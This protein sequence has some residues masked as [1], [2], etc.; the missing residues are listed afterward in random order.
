M[1]RRREHGD[2]WHCQAEPPRERRTLCDQPSQ[3]WPGQAGHGVQLTAF[4]DQRDHPAG[5]GP[6]QDCGKTESSSWFVLCPGELYRHC[7][8]DGQEAQGKTGAG[9]GRGGD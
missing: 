5:S 2:C 3:R 1:L 6:R 7:P 8:D 4:L 9:Q